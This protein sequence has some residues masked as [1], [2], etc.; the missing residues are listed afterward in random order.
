VTTT[1]AAAV[2]LTAAL[3]APALALALAQVPALALPLVL[4]LLLL[5]WTPRQWPRRRWQRLLQ[6]QPFGRLQTGTT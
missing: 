4:M 3:Q 5:S 2:P 6:R 1:P